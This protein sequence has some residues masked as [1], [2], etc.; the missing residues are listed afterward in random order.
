M[1]KVQFELACHKILSRLK[2]TFS[3]M[4]N[5]GKFK[6]KSFMIEAPDGSIHRNSALGFANIVKDAIERIVQGRAINIHGWAIS[7]AEDLYDV[8]D[9]L[10]AEVKIVEI[11]PMAVDFMKRLRATKVDK[12]HMAPRCSFK[13]DFS[14]KAS[15]NILSHI[16]RAE[17][18]PNY[19]RYKEFE[20]FVLANEE[21]LD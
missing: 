20:K 3:V 10:Q 18:D 13:S 6:N 11:P 16:T 21:G 15:R 4:Q 1:T 12:L 9:I 17:V 7:K 8:W 5:Q 14:A 19:R 2:K